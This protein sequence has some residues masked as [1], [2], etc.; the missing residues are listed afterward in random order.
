MRENSKTMQSS[1]KSTA[2]GAIL[3]AVLNRCK[4]EATR[5]EAGREAFASGR[6]EIL[7]EAF[8]AYRRAMA[9]DSGRTELGKLCAS[10]PW[11]VTLQAADDPLPANV[12]CWGACDVDEAAD[13]CT[14]IRYA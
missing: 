13:Y 3:Q 9:S 2:N 14:L 4:A 7:L 8:R 5:R 6:A 10:A 1:S 12:L 11:Q